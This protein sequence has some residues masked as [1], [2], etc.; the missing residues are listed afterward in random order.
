MRTLVAR[1][2]LLPGFLLLAPGGAAQAP[3]SDA[4]TR[5]VGA[6]CDVAA[7]D[8]SRGFPGEGLALVEALLPVVALAD[9][10]S[11][12]RVRLETLRGELEHYRSS[13]AGA[14][15]ERAI[16]LLRAALARAETTGHE[17]SI[18]RA[19]D[20]LGLAVYAE[21][22]QNGDFAAALP[23]LERAL[24]LRRRLGDPRGVAESLFHVGL[25]HQNRTGATGADRKRALELYR[26]ALSI[27]RDGGFKV[28]ES[29]LAR[30]IAAEDQE[31]GDLDAAL[32]GFSRSLALRREAGYR[33]YLSPALL[34]LGSVHLARGA[35]REAEESY[36]EALAVAREI[37]A[38][39]YEVSALLALGRLAQRGGD[40]ERAAGHAKAA[41]ETARRG[42]W[43]DGV[44]EAEALL[45]T[46][47]PATPPA[48]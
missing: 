23:H 29:Y 30:H 41:L 16:E 36:R 1:S 19:A 46:R 44:R 3:S 37:H 48:R 12:D 31:R 38:V 45:G 25:V 22:F 2:L 6:A 20:L 32:A 47:S 18:A 5:L 11:L 33:V 7:A 26:E 14:S 15:E 39:R 24:A 42:G 21:A 27:A 43:E 10:S 13:L 4:L 9:A 8:L 40:G 28:E 34:A 35:A 17:P